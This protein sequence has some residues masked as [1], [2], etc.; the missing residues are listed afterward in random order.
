MNEFSFSPDLL[1]TA[2][3]FDQSQFVITKTITNGVAS[4]KT[5]TK[6]RQ[7][8]DDPRASTNTYTR[9]ICP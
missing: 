4:S 5:D 7:K 1:I 2:S 8:S 3:N 9:Q 6:A